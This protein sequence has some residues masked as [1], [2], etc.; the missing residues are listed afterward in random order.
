MILRKQAHQDCQCLSLITLETLDF[1]WA[2]LVQDYNIASR[3]ETHK[4]GSSTS[5]SPSSPIQV[6]ILVAG[7][8]AIGILCNDTATDL[9]ISTSNSCTRPKK[10]IFWPTLSPASTK[11]KRQSRGGLVTVAVVDGVNGTK[12]GV[13]GRYID[14]RG[15]RT[16]KMSMRLDSETALDFRG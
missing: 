8:K 5:S 7:Q 13:L 14:C 6:M 2:F 9:V 4:P 10:L 3:N 15:V 1:L 11:K 12:R 16:P